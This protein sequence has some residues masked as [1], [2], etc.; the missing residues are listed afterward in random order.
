MPPANSGR[1]LPKREERLSGSRGLLLK[2][3]DLISTPI[4]IDG[5]FDDRCN[6][7][8]RI[9]FALKSCLKEFDKIR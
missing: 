6:P 1:M 2:V 4:L 3:I 7:K 8:A 9:T 5:L